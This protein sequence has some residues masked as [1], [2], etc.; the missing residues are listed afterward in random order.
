MASS[1]PCPKIF[2]LHRAFFIETF[3]NDQLLTVNDPEYELVA[4]LLD[5]PDIIIDHVDKDGFTALHEAA[6]SGHLPVVQ[7][8]VEKKFNVNA[9]DKDGDT[10]AMRAASCNHLKVVQYLH[11]HGAVLADQVNADGETIAS[12]AAHSD[13]HRVLRYIAETDPRLVSSTTTSSEGKT[14]LMVAAAKGSIKS[15]QYILDKFP[16]DEVTAI[17]KDGRSALHFAAASGSKKVVE[18]ILKNHPD[19]NVKCSNG[20]TALHYAVDDI[21]NPSVVNVLLASGADATI[22]NDTDDLPV[23]YAATQGG[24]D[25]FS[26]LKKLIEI[27]E[28]QCEWLN[29]ESGSCRTVL[30]IVTSHSNF[31][32]YSL[33]MVELFCARP[34]LA[35][36]PP[37]LGL[38]GGIPLLNL[39]EELS[40]RTVYRPLPGGPLGPPTD[41]WRLLE[42]I[43][44][45]V[46]RGA[47]VDFTNPKGDTALHILCF[48]NLK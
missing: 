7:L 26:V 47:S 37:R 48:G 42:A 46:G 27:A 10:P 14:T 29:E 18:M 13:C 9:S 36:E 16:N 40:K 32:D 31:T 6:Q 33:K 20:C 1:P 3:T 12:V 34:E 30:Q 19:V 41:A 22:K 43:K 23:H 8:L 15:T 5:D 25:N 35:L 38:V 11:Q 39:V 45:L 21:L 2:Q 44:L 17:T 24:W 28:D 4:Q